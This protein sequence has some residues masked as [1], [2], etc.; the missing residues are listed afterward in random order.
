MTDHGEP[1]TCCHAAAALATDGGQ[2]DPAHV[3]TLLEGLPNNWGRWGD[4]DERGT[5]NLL[6]SAEAAAGM[7]AALLEGDDDVE[8]FTLGLPMTGETIPE[9][10]PEAAGD[11]AFPGRGAAR[12][13]NLFD[14]RS[15]RDGEREPLTGMR[16]S[17]DRFVTPF[18]LQG[19][20]HL[21]AL[22]HAWY[23]DELYN[24]FDPVET[25]RVKRFDRAETGIGG[26]DVVE[27]RG[28]EKLSIAPL[29]DVGLAGRGVLLDVGRAHDDGD[30]NGRLPLETEIGLAD[31]EATADAQ[32][33]EVRE[34][35]ILLVRT[36]SMGRTRDPEAAWNP[37]KEA[38]LVFSKALVEWVH[39]RDLALLGAD[40]I[41]VEKVTQRVDGETYVLPLHGA[42][43]RNLGLPLA[44]LLWLDD[45]AAACADDDIY[46]FLFTAAPLHVQ[47]ATGGPVNPVVL[48]AS[49]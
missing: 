40:N 41:G 15:Y 21:D 24:G 5:L 8:R 9:D 48:K 2:P 44:E 45:L 34:R 6:G 14:E 37:T 30:E 3:A 11:P 43:L 20:T 16:F 46:E 4:D 25:A 32:G 27:T 1:C 22:G 29:A 47:R 13:D 39:D 7:R 49:D 17:D 36:G 12:R 33:V 38:G 28:H 18:Y 26:E 35:D 19:T 10:E 23:G 42:F 31:L